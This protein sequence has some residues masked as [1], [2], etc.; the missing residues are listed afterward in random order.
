MTDVTE[1]ETVESRLERSASESVWLRAVGLSALPVAVAVVVLGVWELASALGVIDPILLPAP[2]TIFLA[3]IKLLGD[4]YFWTSVQTTVGETIAGLGIGAA[5]GLLIGVSSILFPLFRRA[6]YPYVLAIQVL[7]RI[8]LAPI[9][10][11]WFGF[12]F[13]SKVVMAALLAFFP[14]AINTMVGMASTDRDAMLMMESL[15]ASRRDMLRHLMLPTAIP[16]IL[17]GLKTAMTLALIGAIVGEFVG[18]SVGLG[19]L[20]AKLNFQFEVAAGFG[21]LFALALIGLILYGLISLL[22]RRLTRWQ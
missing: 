1:P 15:G 18:A 5:V 7:P 14:V 16:F 19:V 6:V 12:G 11:T 20:L 17:A 2:S 8:A 13:T 3:F 22:E 21:V 10:L 9:V 4:S